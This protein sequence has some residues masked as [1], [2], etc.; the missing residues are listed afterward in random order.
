MKIGDVVQCPADR[1][2][3]PYSARVTFISETVNYNSHG[4]AYRWVTVHK[5]TGKSGAVWPS[6]RLGWVMK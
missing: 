5:L 4:A 1:G 2:D 3:K 6:H